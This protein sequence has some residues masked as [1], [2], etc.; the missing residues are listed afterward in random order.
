[1]RWNL[2]STISSLEL[3]LCL[4]ILRDCLLLWVSFQALVILA[5]P[6]LFVLLIIG[7]QGW[8]RRFIPPLL[9]VAG[10]ISI[11]P[12]FNPVPIAATESGAVGALLRIRNVLESHRCGNV[13][14]AVADVLS[15]EDSRL[16]RFYRFEYEEG[17]DGYRIAALLKRQARS[18]GCIRNFVIGH[19][20]VVHYTMES[21]PATQVDAVVDIPLGASVKLLLPEQLGSFQT[22]T[23][24]GFSDDGQRTPDDLLPQPHPALG[25]HHRITRIVRFILYRSVES[26]ATGVQVDPLA[27]VGDVLRGFVGNSGHVVLKDEHSGGMMSVRSDLMDIDHRAISDTA[28]LIKPLPAAALKF[29]RCLRFAT[30]ETVR[31]NC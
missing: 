31:C 22:Y 23:Q 19:D 8:K 11:Q 13:E 25:Y 21:R 16:R 18:C 24:K 3:A 4:F 27:Q 9:V 5:L 29:F 10:I 30:R 12:H 2:A 26:Q 1:M 28:H 15:K 7:F 14:A 6:W 20:G 17:Q